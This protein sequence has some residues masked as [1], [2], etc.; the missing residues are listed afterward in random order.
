M[1]SFWKIYG[2][3][4]KFNSFFIFS[5]FLLSPLLFPTISQRESVQ[6]NWKSQIVQKSI[7]SKE[8]VLTFLHKIFLDTLQPVNS[9]KWHTSLLDRGSGGNYL[10]KT[11][12]KTFQWWISYLNSSIKMSHLVLE[13]LF[14]LATKQSSLG[15]WKQL[16]L[17]NVW[18]HWC[19]GL[20]F[21]Q[22]KYPFKYYFLA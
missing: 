4:R 17:K 19:S 7:F 2:F 3:L 18:M 13:L 22:R 5:T 12:N 6:N 14:D 10:E 11:I 8:V 21:I 1:V 9:A 20:T 16:R 15:R